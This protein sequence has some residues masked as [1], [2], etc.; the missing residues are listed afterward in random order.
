MPSP[1]VQNWAFAAHK[2]DLVNGAKKK[3]ILLVDRCPFAYIELWKK[4]QLPIHGHACTNRPVP[5]QICLSTTGNVRHYVWSYLYLDHMQCI[6]PGQKLTEEEVAKYAIHKEVI[7]FIQCNYKTYCH[8][9]M[10][11]YNLWSLEETR[12]FG[13]DLH[14]GGGGGG[15][16][17]GADVQRQLDGVVSAADSY[18]TQQILIRS[19]VHVGAC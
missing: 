7:R 8:L 17:S 14:G 16:R 11:A 3:N 12:T 2:V 19:Y 9:I 13:G 6:H 4:V 10:L 5:C 18:C 1:F 15:G